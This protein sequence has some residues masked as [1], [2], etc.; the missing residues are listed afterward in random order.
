VIGRIR[1]PELSEDE[2]LVGTGGID[3]TMLLMLW[4]VRHD[5]E[6]RQGR[7][8]SVPPITRTQVSS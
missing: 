7:M 8:G 6:E 2:C 4:V 3:M 1:R 5:M